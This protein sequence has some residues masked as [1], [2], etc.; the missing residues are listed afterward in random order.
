MGM[1]AAPDLFEM[2][3]DDT[4]NYGHLFHHATH[5]FEWAIFVETGEY[6]GLNL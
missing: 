4:D 3:G 5:I 2:E 1:R 6:V